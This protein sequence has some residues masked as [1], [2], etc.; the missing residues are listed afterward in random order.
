ML[1]GVGALR[2][3]VT[4]AA[5]AFGDVF[6]TR[7]LRRIQLAWAGS[8]LGNWSYI[9][10]LGVYAYDQGGAAAVGLIGVLRLIPAAV[11]APLLSTLA[12][13]MRRERVMI[14]SDLLRAALMVA[15]G[16]VIAVDGPAPVVYAIIVVATI[17]GT[18]FRPAQAALLPSLVRDP[19]EL[20]AANVVA[21]TVESVGSFAGPAVGGLLLAFTNP[22]TVFMVN[23]LSF[24]WSAA[25]VAGVHSEK[26]VREEH[27]DE[28]DRPSFLREVSA[29][30]TSIV[31]EPHLRLLSGLYAAQTLVAG[32]ASVFT[33]AVALDL[34]D[35]GNSG[36]GW[37]S[38]ASGLGGFVGGLLALGLAMRSRLATDLALGLVLNGLP[39]ALV[40]A[41]PS[42]PVALAAL[43]IV[44]IGNSV[45]D[46]SAITLLQR[47]V[48]DAVLG[49]VLGAIESILLASLGIGALLAP[50]LISV[51]GLRVALLAAGAL[52]PV[53][54]GLS[55]LALRRIDAGAEAPAE[56]G[57]LAAIPIF[58]P[59][60]LQTLERLASQLGELRLPAGTLI[61]RQGDPGDRFYV[62]AEGEVE[63]EGRRHGP[64]AF[65]GE[66]ALLKDVPRTATVAA[67]TDVRL[68][69]LE[70]EEFIAA[71][72]GH[73][74]SAAA[75][76]AIVSA[77]LGALRPGVAPV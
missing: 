56:T 41:F 29:G 67:A 9:V 44:G 71:V 40:A 33:V 72:T 6:R 37:L 3:R 27:G 18:V 31:G 16:A 11:A 46:V 68:L 43:A 74:P 77:R 75:A 73:E 19:R 17:A 12:D 21:S 36:V 53:L 38:A 55:W 47:A 22:E 20:S 64:G 28:A 2:Q 32:A 50:L 42:V 15:A 1:L 63:I 25:L 48:P 7:E 49:R 76:E 5:A 69:T 10:A 14:S 58:Q 45:V 24:V 66:I 70:R 13:R 54:V 62:I 23:A 59:L 52:L 4:T 30:M 57:L 8:V 34:L 35:I 39:F 26:P 60:P 65:F 61:L 51:G